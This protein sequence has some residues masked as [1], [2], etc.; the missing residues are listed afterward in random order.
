MYATALSTD[1][2]VFPAQAWSSV[3]GG[4]DELSDRIRAA[5]VGALLERIEIRARQ[6]QG[7]AAQIRELATT[8]ESVPGAAP[9]ERSLQTLANAPTMDQADLGRMGRDVIALVDAR[10]AST[11]AYLETARFAV[12]NSDT[13]F[14]AS[15]IPATVEAALRETPPDAL[16]QAVEA[17]RSAAARSPVDMATIGRAATSLLAAM[18]R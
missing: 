13:A 4:A 5:R 18:A 3:R 6:G 14:F 16:P 2:T 12:A 9:V 15:G 1:G 11:A 17:L 7:A 10:I 8:I